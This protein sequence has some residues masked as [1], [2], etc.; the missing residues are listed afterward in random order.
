MQTAYEPALLYREQDRDAGR[1]KKLI[2]LPMGEMCLL[3]VIRCAAQHKVHGRI[4]AAN[5]Y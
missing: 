2:E 5:C 1:M 3:E 4:A